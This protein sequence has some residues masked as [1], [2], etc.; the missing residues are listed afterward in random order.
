MAELYIQGLNVPRTI[1]EALTRFSEN[2]S[3]EREVKKGANGYLFF[4]RNKVLRTEIA[5][6][7]YY[8]GNDRKF[9]AEPRR[10]SQI[11]AENVISVFDA[12]YIDESWAY[13]V[14]PYCSGGDIED[15]LCESTVGNLKAIAL[16]VQ[17]LNGLSHLHAQRFLHCDLK[18][19]N[20]YLN[21]IGSAVIGDFGSIAKLPPG[22][23]T[24]PASSNTLLY[25][26]PEAIDSL[27]YGFAGDIYQV[28]LVLFQLLGG[29]LPSEAAAW[30]SKQE[31]VHL[32]QLI[33]DADQSIYVNQCMSARIV[34]GKVLDLSSLPP[35]VGE[36]LKRVIRKACNNN[37]EK[38]FETAA[39]FLAQLNKIQPA[40]PDW[41]IIDG[42]PTLNASTNYR[43]VESHGVFQ[44]QKHRGENP[45]RNDS[46]ISKASLA[47]TV[48]VI[49]DR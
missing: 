43:I 32:A 35:W 44:V 23:N 45:W 36:P 22:Q 10:L 26:P 15:L 39:H 11:T 9:H 40:V 6:K 19:S 2:Y 30:L 12:G 18:P 8:W 13:F 20:I 28:G 14:T 31:L 38:R 3:L 7:I 5:I 24:I 16:T 47:E 46:S 25:R 37:P 27:Q 1:K 4:G 49:N 17:I 34:R 48:D 33:S 42:Y 21:T 29:H 41:K